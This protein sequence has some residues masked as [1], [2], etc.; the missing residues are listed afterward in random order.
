MLGPFRGFRGASGLRR[1][2]PQDGAAGGRLGHKD[3][4]LRARSIDAACRHGGPVV[5]LLQRRHK[6]LHAVL[7][8]H[9][10]RAA[11]PARTYGA[12]HHRPPTVS[13]SGVGRLWIGRRLG[14]GRDG[15]ASCF[16][17][18]GGGTHRMLYVPAVGDVSGQWERLYR[19]HLVTLLS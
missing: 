1:G 17:R 3:G 4:A 13:P 8:H 10:H 9:G 14:A 2:Q 7:A 11:A 18:Q 5:P 15:P 12:G 16:D 19:R 6:P